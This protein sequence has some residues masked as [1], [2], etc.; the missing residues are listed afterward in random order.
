MRSIVM[1]F[2]SSGMLNLSTLYLVVMTPSM[3]EM[4]DTSSQGPTHLLVKDLDFPFGIL[5]VNR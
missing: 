1:A 3:G 4:T 5:S 2:V